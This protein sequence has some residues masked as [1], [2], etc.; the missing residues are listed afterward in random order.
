MRKLNVIDFVVYRWRYS[1][2]YIGVC[3][4]LIC[5]LFVAGFFIPG[6]LTDQEMHAVITSSDL[7]IKNFSPEMIVNAPYHALQKLSFYT[8]GVSNISIKLPSL[9]I[10]FFSGI[11]I[12][13]LLRTWFKQN[14]AV[15]VALISVTTG[16]FLIVAQTGTPYILY[17]FWSVWLL[18][19]ASMMSK[20]ARFLLGWKVL[21]FT[22]MALSL[23]TPLSAYILIAIISATALHPHLRYTV[24]QLSKIQLLTASIT[25][26]VI[27]APIVYALYLKPVVAL[28][29]LGVPSKFPNIIANL[30]QLFTQYFDFMHPIYG[31]FMTPIYG[32]PSVLLMLIGLYRMLTTK[33]TAKSYII[34]AWL[35]LLVP[36]LIMNPDIISITFV[37]L[38]LLMA[39]GIDYLVRYW[40]RL[41]PRNPY[42]RIAGLIPLI[43]LIV[44]M[45]L[46]GLERYGYGYVYGEGVA[47]IFS[48][49][50]TLVRAE[51]ASS[52]VATTLRVA[53][54][55]VSF[56][57]AYRKYERGST[58][59]VT[60][61][62]TS[63]Q[64]TLTPIESAIA[65][66]KV[67]STVIVSREARSSD[68]P[69]VPTKIITNAY[70]HE[71]DRFY[72]YKN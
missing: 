4:V 36:I 27:V 7:S 61:S 25:G 37:P 23:Y 18:L 14:V 62:Q 21:L 50:L 30:G 39:V 15:L 1:L 44:S 48:K 42:A 29:L 13:L 67:Q 46:T 2:G 43:I 9:A 66:N 41:F 38:L 35:L 60:T 11:G 51:I 24:S 28:E 5:L 54:S 65:A 45:T 70:A 33:Y 8:F 12:L 20:G 56:Y 71:A 47:S 57:E 64:R 17:I 34:I 72:V 53:P 63:K 68:D 10:G 22:F 59:Q 58:F 32:L 19:S 40:Y 16:Q 6:G 69:S 26:L 55:E 31:A 3:L 52:T 49:D